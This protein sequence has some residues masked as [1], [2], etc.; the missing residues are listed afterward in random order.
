VSK[1]R[2]RLRAEREAAHAVARAKRARQVARRERRRA[3]LR[4]L[5]PRLPDRRVGRVG[6]RPWWQRTVIAIVAV[7]ALAAIWTYVDTLALRIGL[8][9]LVLVALPVFVVAAFDRRY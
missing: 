8:T 2:A 3:M 7:S 1:E 4:R 6:G 5:T 9:L